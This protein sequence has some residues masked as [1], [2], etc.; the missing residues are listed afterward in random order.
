MV[1]CG[2]IVRRGKRK[3]LLGEASTLQLPGY[4]RELLEG[5]LF[6]DCSPFA[7]GGQR[8]NAADVTPGAWTAGALNRH[9]GLIGNDGREG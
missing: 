9:A 8:Q 1:L 5:V 3:D 7:S 6:V 2:P 4:K